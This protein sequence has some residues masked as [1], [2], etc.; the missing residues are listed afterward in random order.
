MK[1]HEHITSALR[2]MKT[3]AEATSMAMRQYKEIVNDGSSAMKEC[4]QVGRDA[5]ERYENI[6]AELIARGECVI[7]HHHW[8]K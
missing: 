5:Q 6:C 2:E 3:E 8:P 7:V 1:L 4:E